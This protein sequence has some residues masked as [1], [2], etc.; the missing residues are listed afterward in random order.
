MTFANVSLKNTKELTKGSAIM[1][2]TEEVKRPEL[3]KRKYKAINSC[4]VNSPGACANK[5]GEYENIDESPKH[6][7]KIKRAL[8]IIKE[9][10]VD[11]EKLRLV[12]NAYAYNNFG[13]VAVIPI[14]QEDYELLT[15]VLL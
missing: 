14:T 15:E 3:T 10:K 2:L 12:A 1:R 9:K 8:D 11:T 4:Y 13:K 5:L 7:A 6:L